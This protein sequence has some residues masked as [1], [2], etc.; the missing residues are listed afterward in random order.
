MDA[1][2]NLSPD[3]QRR[4]GIAV[5]GNPSEAVPLR[6]RG[7]PPV[8]GVAAL[9]VMTKRDHFV[10]ARHSYNGIALPNLVH[11]RAAGNVRARRKDD[12]ADCV[13][14]LLIFCSPVTFEQPVSCRGET[15]GIRHQTGKIHTVLRGNRYGQR[16]ENRKQDYLSSADKVI[17]VLKRP[18]FARPSARLICAR[19]D[20][21]R[22]GSRRC[23]DGGLVD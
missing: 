12:E 22:L 18:G 11:A 20:A 3:S 2:R 17:A 13:T 14:E 5:G 8:G 23:R 19:Q 15:L 4:S 6:D 21:L 1:L 10:D 9:E 16:W 7:C